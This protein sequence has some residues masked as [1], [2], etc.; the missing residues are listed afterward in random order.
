MS[1]KYKIFNQDYPHFVTSTVVNWIDLFTRNEYRNV[2]L[3]SL[4]YC[5]KHKGLLLYAYCIMTNHVHL[6]LGSENNKLEN[7]MRDFKSFTSRKLRKTLECNLQESRKEWIL[8]MMYR[9][10][11]SKRSNKGF[12]LWQHNYHPIELSSD[13]LFEQ[14][15]EY[16]HQNPVKAGFVEKP[17]E[18]LYSSARNFAGFDA[19]IDL[20]INTDYL[21]A[22][23]ARARRSR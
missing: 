13:Y 23:K 6:I 10:G 22:F 19:M 16:I 1:Q 8:K 21:I 7:I 17:E 5:R 11:S 9:A 15:L 4:N 12:Q 18:F 2:L 14:K 3:E 20:D